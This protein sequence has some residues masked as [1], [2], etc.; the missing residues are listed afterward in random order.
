MF[1]SSLM[2]SYRALLAK[3]G[4]KGYLEEP[5]SMVHHAK[6]KIWTGVRP[7]SID[8]GVDPKGAFARLRTAVL[9]AKSEGK[10]RAEEQ[11]KK[12]LPQ[13]LLRKKAGVPSEFGEMFGENGI[14]RSHS[15][16]ML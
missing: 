12:A 13:T 14:T 1:Q 4:S 8:I 2:H 6:A 3:V 15:C 16:I 7:R 5:G 11:L 9:A 10:R